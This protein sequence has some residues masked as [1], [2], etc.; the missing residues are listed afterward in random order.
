MIH[1]HFN[2]NISAKDVGNDKASNLPH[3]E[4]FSSSLAQAGRLRYFNF[5][6]GALVALVLN[7]ERNSQCRFSP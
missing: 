4:I 1:S 5:T 2:L 3:N 7:A 6:G